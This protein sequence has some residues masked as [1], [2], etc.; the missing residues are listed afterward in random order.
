MY[1][2]NPIALVGSSQFGVFNP[3]DSVCA[4][5]RQQGES[6]IDAGCGLEPELIV[7]HLRA[8]G[9]DSASLRAA[10]FTHAHADHADG[11]FVMRH[12]QEHVDWAIK[13][14]SGLALPPNFAASTPKVIPTD[15]S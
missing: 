8:D 10:V 3:F 9:S 7:I 13:A 5:D 12:G 15:Y 4:I 14:L 2:P 11:I 6:L 1:L